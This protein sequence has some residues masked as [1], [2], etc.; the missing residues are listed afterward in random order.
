MM[1]TALSVIAAAASFFVGLL[2]L[3]FVVAVLF[4]VGTRTVIVTVNETRKELANEKE[5]SEQI[6]S[7][8]S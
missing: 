5:K 8:G 1:N 4:R 2:L 7:G 6:G 3:S